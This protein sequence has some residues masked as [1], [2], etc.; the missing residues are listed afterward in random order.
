MLRTCGSRQGQEVCR[1]LAAA[2]RGTRLS[3][4]WMIGHLQIDREYEID[5]EL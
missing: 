2:G 5:L 1:I 4:G 3:S